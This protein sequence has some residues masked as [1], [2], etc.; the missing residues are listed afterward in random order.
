MLFRSPASLVTAHPELAG[1]VALRLD[2]ATAKLMP[3][4]LKGQVAVAMY[5]ST[6]Q[7]LDA[8]GAQTAIAL[9]ALYAA[10]AR[11]RT[12]GVGFA[13]SG[14]VDFSLWA[15]TAQQVTLLTWPA[16]SADQPLDT[17]RRTAMTRDGAGAW[18]TSLGSSA[19]NAR[20]LYEIGRAHV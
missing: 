14:R 10:S 7:L 1:A 6:G 8:T 4:I 15:P 13:G 19:R 17:A 5:G 2:K 16:G 20:Y 9:D 3:E 12:Y 18:S 11:T